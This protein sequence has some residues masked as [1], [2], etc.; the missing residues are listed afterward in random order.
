MDDGPSPAE[1]EENEEIAELPHGDGTSFHDDDDDGRRS[2]TSIKSAHSSLVRTR[3]M[4]STRC[5][6]E[7][8]NFVLSC[9]QGLD[10]LAKN[11]RSELKPN[12][13]MERIK[14]LNLEQIPE[15]YRSNTPEEE[16]TSTASRSVHC[17]RSCDR[18]HGRWCSNTSKTFDASS[19]NCASLRSGLIFFCRHE[20]SAAFAVGLS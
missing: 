10:D 1:H 8:C 11:P 6:C 5:V 12:M 17:V 9:C 14:K 15:T 7:L 16:V 3:P 20:R 4:A 2:R 18:R 13:K 19:S